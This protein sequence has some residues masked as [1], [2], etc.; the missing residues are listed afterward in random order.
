[1][2]SQAQFDQMIPNRNAFYTYSGLVTAL[3][4]YPGFATTGSST[5]QAQEAALSFTSILGVTPGNNLT[6]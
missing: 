2:V 5:V 1:M 6:C 4:S 3:S